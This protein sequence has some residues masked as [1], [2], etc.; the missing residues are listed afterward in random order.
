MTVVTYAL[1]ATVF[2]LI[3][4]AFGLICVAAS[5]VMG[6]P[7]LA[8]DIAFVGTAGGMIWGAAG[9]ILAF[10]L[11]VQKWQLEVLPKPTKPV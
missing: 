10:G 2:A 11:C 1:S 4:L 8:T 6:I 3:S 9:G 7:E 5:F